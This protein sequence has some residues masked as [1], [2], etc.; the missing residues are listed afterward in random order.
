MIAHGGIEDGCEFAHAGEE[1]DLCR[2]SVVAQA[3]VDC[4]HQPRLAQG[5][6]LRPLVPAGR[7]QHDPRGARRRSR[8]ISA[9][10]PAA[11]LP[12]ENP[13]P[14]GRAL[15]V[16]SIL[17]NVDPDKNPQ[18]GRRPIPFLQVRARRRQLFGREMKDDAEAL[19]DAGKST[20]IAYGRNG[21]PVP[22]CRQFSA[23]SSR[24]PC[25]RGDAPHSNF[26]GPILTM[27]PRHARMAGTARPSFP[28]KTTSGISQR[29]PAV[30]GRSRFRQYQGLCLC[31]RSAALPRSSPPT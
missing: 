14:S 11:S 16:Q 25:C 1:G 21:T 29:G 22:R 13:M 15:H 26:G 28:D 19:L 10:R 12:T 27:P 31:L 2:L 20:T 7:P 18:C 3:I 17:R 4:R 9:A 8:A 24:G 6:P 30:S 23:M 5:Q